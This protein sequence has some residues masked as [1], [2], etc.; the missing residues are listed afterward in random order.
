MPIPVAIWAQGVIGDMPNCAQYPAA[1]SNYEQHQASQ[2]WVVL[3]AVII[4]A[5]VLVVATVLTIVIVRRNR[6]RRLPPLP[7]PPPPPHPPFPGQF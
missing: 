4:I 2:G 7:P 5:A 3:A 1:C 6:G